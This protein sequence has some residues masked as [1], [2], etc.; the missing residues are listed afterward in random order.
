MERWYIDQGPDSDVVI[1]S[2]IRIARNFKK[3]PFAVRMTQD[4]AKKIVSV[5]ENLIPYIN[6]SV[7][8]KVRW[9]LT[10]NLEGI[11]KQALIEKHLISPDFVKSKNL[12]GI[13]L[14]DDETLCIMVNEEDHLRIQSLTSGLQLEKAWQ[15]CNKISNLIEAKNEIAFDERYGYLT[16]CPTNVGTGIRASVMMHLPALTMT[17]KINNI[18]DACSKVS[19]AVRGLYGEN[20]QASGNMFQ[21][22]NQVTLGQTEEEII[23][24]ITA[25]SK[26]IMEH[27]RGLRD[28]LYKHN[29]NKFEDRIYRSY[30]I[31]SNSRIISCEES[32]ELISDVRLGV[33]MGIIKNINIKTL[34]E[35]I[36]MVQPATLQ[37]TLGLPLSCQERDVKRAEL[38]R[39][40][41]LEQPNI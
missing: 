23:S 32:L 7:K 20:T 27:E 8:S 40:K 41:L 24:N 29:T 1:S 12:G 4:N 11:D 18:L 30:G 16:C 36:L 14:S 3:F 9:F 17:S 33:D 19:V 26:Q 2:R 39:G 6:K 10:D 35:L 5:V 34:N 28:S 15:D 25:I 38:I 22:S 31:L 21:I 13:V 37:K